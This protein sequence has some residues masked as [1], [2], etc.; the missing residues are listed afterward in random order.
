MVKIVIADAEGGERTFL[1][2]DCFNSNDCLDRAGE[3]GGERAAIT[4]GATSTIHYTDGK[5]AVIKYWRQ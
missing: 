3:Y 5:N 4:G 2:A 1:V